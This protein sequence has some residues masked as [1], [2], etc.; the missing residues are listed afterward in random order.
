M[1]DV[2]IFQTVD[3]SRFQDELLEMLCRTARENGRIEITQCEGGNCVLISKA[4][5]D[6]LELALDVLS[7]TEAGKQLHHTVEQF[8]QLDNADGRIPSVSVA[9]E[10]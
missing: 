5:L 4:E 1:A 6:S 2:S 8:V 9:R 7:N 3:G 10:I